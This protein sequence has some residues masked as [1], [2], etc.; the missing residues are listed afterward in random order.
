MI[1]QSTLDLMKKA[2]DQ[3]M[4]VYAQIKPFLNQ[5]E[6]LK[7]NTYQ[8]VLPDFSYLEG[9]KKIVNSYTIK[10]LA[11]QSLVLSRFQSGYFNISPEFLE[12]IKSIQNLV[13]WADETNKK[14]AK[15][16]CEKYHYF[17]SP[18]IPANFR[19][20][21]VSAY[22]KN[23]RKANVDKEFY[24]ICKQNNWKILN[25]VK[26]WKENKYL[27]KRLPVIKDAVSILRK[28]KK[29]PH[30]VI[31]PL[32]ISQVNG[33]MLDIAETNNVS[34]KFTSKKGKLETKLDIDIRKEVLDKI[35][36]NENIFQSD[37]ALYIIKDVLFGVAD[38][39]KE[40]KIGQVDKIKGIKYEDLEDN[41]LGF[42]RHK[43]LHGQDTK[44][45]TKS[46]MIRAFLLLDFLAECLIRFS[47]LNTS[48]KNL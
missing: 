38:A 46:N 36:L 29:S 41:K 20:Y 8:A 23:S 44:G 1:D 48:E 2:S 3:A 7:L 21:L 32:L 26:K 33:I 37:L 31:L 19:F 16:I 22:N 45:L 24:K 13:L 18:N 25:F 47:L 11:E 39:N 14:E 15:K 10:Y 12:R 5:I 35:K 42:S 27:A 34:F 28:N 40:A 17:I 9:I 4:V 6:N 30:R 43:I